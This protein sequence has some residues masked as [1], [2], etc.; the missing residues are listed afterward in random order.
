M[1]KKPLII[2]RRSGYYVNTIINDPA[3]IRTWMENNLTRAD[4]D[5]VPD[6]YGY[7]PERSLP[8]SVK[9]CC[10]A[11]IPADNFDVMRAPAF[12]PEFA[13]KFGMVLN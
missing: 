13:R 1:G 3:A 2:I 7:L 4:S 9:E 8:E 6:K 12:A 10:V 11:F 5:G